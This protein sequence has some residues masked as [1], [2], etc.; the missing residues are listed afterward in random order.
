MIPEI[1]YSPVKFYAAIVCLLLSQVIRAQEITYDNVYVDYDSAIEYKNLRIIPIRPKN[2]LGNNA[3][4]AISLSQ[5]VR[6]ELQ[7]YLKEVQL[8][9]K[10]YISFE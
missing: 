7:P 10:M 8:P 9:Q 5:A 6:R 1:V 2:G 3:P 4:H